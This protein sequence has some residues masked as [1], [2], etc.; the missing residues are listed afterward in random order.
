MKIHHD[1]L[2]LQRERTSS[3]NLIHSLPPPPPRGATV[4]E[5]VGLL[6]NDRVRN[7]VRERSYYPPN[8]VS[9]CFFFSCLNDF[10]IKFYTSFSSLGIE[11]AECS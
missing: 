7:D 2:K 10:K 11:T 8:S 4:S 1:I 9:V 3:L 5:H 6:V